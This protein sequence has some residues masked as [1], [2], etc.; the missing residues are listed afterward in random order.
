[1]RADRAQLRSRALERIK[2]PI[3][4]K[5]YPKNRNIC[6]HGPRRHQKPTTALVPASTNE[7][8]AGRLFPRTSGPTR[9]ENLRSRFGDGPE[10]RRQIGSPQPEAA[11]VARGSLRAP[12]ASASLAAGRGSR[13]RF[14]ASLPPDRRSRSR[15]S[16]G[17]AFSSTSDSRW[18][19]MG[20][21]ALTAE[22][23]SARHRAGASLVAI[24]PAR[25]A[26][27]GRPDSWQRHSEAGA[28][29]RAEAVVP[30]PGPARPGCGR[31]RQRPELA[32]R[33]TPSKH[34]HVLRRHGPYRGWP[35]LRSS[36]CRLGWPSGH[37][38]AARTLAAAYRPKHQRRRTSRLLR[39]P[40]AKEA[41][42]PPA[43]ARPPHAVACA[44]LVLGQPRCPRC[45]EQ[46]EHERLLVGALVASTRRV[47][48]CGSSEGTSGDANWRW[49]VS[50]NQA[51][52]R[53]PPVAVSSEE[54]RARTSA[55]AGGTC[56]SGARARY[57]SS[58]SR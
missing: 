2:W 43:A 52:L 21:I 58:W 22:R 14:G 32:G 44:T 40:M 28:A 29:V 1:M 26:T 37:L 25:P 18:I 27:T 34:N 30:R 53:P 31:L 17:T 11:V 7:R 10:G 46:Q 42:M 20:T 24:G 4:P 57:R 5:A 23:P 39:D 47:R 3:L 56:G 48:G 41:P 12:D 8:R 19:P 6:S 50:C 33:P 55:S 35:R 51:V 49:Q 45:L 36:G 13:P 9:L 16:A 38:V 15:P 54:Q